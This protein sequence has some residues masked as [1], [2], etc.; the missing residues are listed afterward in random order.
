MV[1]IA[2][3]SVLVG[4]ALGSRYK[5]LIVVPVT[6]LAVAAVAMVCISNGHGF[7]STAAAVALVATSLELGYFGGSFASFAL[8]SARCSRGSDRSPVIRTIGRKGA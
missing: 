6:V 3:V 2:I 7:W 8:A 5:V 1:T 4:A